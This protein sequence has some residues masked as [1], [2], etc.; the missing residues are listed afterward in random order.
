MKLVFT[1]KN[2][3]DTTISR[4]QSTPIK[5]RKSSLN[6]T[7]GSSTLLLEKKPS[8]RRNSS[9]HMNIKV[10]DHLLAAEVSSDG[11]GR[12]DIVTSLL[13]KGAKVNAVDTTRGLPVLIQAASNGHLEAMNA[14]IEHGADLNSQTKRTGNSALHEAVTRG[15]EGK[16][17]IKSLLNHGANPTIRNKENL[18]PCELASKLGH[19]RLVSLFANHLGSGLLAP[20]VKRQSQTSLNT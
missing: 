19:K 6:S 7:I 17:A 4:Y 1:L 9:S 10:E 16:D 11:E 2:D 15:M 8:L 14:L 13:E 20:L 18:T 5:G 3:T 12:K